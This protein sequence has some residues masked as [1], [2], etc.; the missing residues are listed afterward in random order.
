V[1]YEIWSSRGPWAIQVL[2]ADRAQCWTGVALKA[3]NQRVGR[4][5]VRALL[6]QLADTARFL[7]GGGVNADFFLFDPPGVPYGAH[8]SNGRVI[9]RPSATLPVFAIDSAGAPWI[10]VLRA[11]GPMPADSLPPRLVPIHPLEAVGGRPVLLRDSIPAT[12]LDSNGGPNFAPVRHPRTAIGIASGGRRLL[13]V[14]VD[15]R[16]LP[17]SDGMTLRELAQLMLALGARDAINLDGGGSTTMLINH[18][19]VM[20]TLNRPSDA[21]GERPV[22]NALALVQRCARR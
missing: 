15:G 17:F 12:D 14:T 3:G 7:V 16:Q 1:H 19:G 13:F 8:V 6:Q 22:G 4:A 9:N 21:A 20:A 5:P 10:G 2:D 11:A 18:G